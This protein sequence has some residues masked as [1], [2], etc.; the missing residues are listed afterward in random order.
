[1]SYLKDN[2]KERKLYLTME[3]FY[4]I[5]KEEGIYELTK[6]LRYFIANHTKAR[7]LGTVHGIKLYLHGGN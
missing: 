5:C 6:Q 2:P 4:I 1:M 3:G 7:Y